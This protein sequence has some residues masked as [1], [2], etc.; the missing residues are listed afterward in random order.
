MVHEE[1]KEIFAVGLSEDNFCLDSA[2]R[3]VR[4]KRGE[5]MGKGEVAILP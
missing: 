1:F 3:R 4:W 5:R 2:R